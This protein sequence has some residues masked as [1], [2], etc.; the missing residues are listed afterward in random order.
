MSMIGWSNKPSMI[1]I[2]HT[3]GTDADPSLDTS[4]HTFEIVDSY[5]KK[6][7]GF[8][9]SLGHYIGYHYFIEKDGKVTQGRSDSDEGAHTIGQNNRSIGICL[10]GNF[11][12]Y[13][14]TPEQIESLKNLLTA[15]C[16]TYRIDPE[17]IFPH[18]KFAHKSCFGSRLPDDWCQK[19]LEKKGGIIE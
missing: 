2:H 3:S 8:R 17:R 1:I 19:L 4:H 18:R 10:A 11:D 16:L 15:K 13:D 9:S 5:H 7:W 12:Y 6:L 14:P